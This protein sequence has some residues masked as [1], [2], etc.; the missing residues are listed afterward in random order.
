MKTRLKSQIIEAAHRL[1]FPLAGVTTPD[2]PAGMQRYESWLA[3]GYHGD[4]DYL[5]SERARNRRADPGLILPDCRSILMLATPYYPASLLAQEELQIAA[6]ALGR[7]YH[8]TLVERMNLLADTIAALTG[9]PFAGKVYTDTGPLLEREL[10]HRAGLGWIGRNSCLIHPQYGSHLL[11]SE[12]LLDLDLEPD[13]PFEKDLCGTCQR[14]LQACPT[15]CILDN[16]TLDATRCISYLTIESRGPIPE[17][18]R[19]A[20]GERFFGC[21]TCQD[22]CPWNQHS[23]ASSDDPAFQ[24]SARLLSSSLVDFITLDPQRWRAPYK[25]SPLLRAKR[26]GLARNA[27]VVAGNRRDAGLLPAL[28][29]ALRSDPDPLVRQHAAWAMG[30]IGGKAARCA[31]KKAAGCENNAD[32]Q[33]A[34]QHASRMN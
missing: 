21:D 29:T 11:L 25:E 16:R 12:I 8:Y 27:C 20:I 30:R 13:A 5:A 18:L 4:M 26:R 31:L 6:Y 15:A 22:V 1:G 7:D 2:P 10:A 28:E 34:I 32:V 3:A 33:A 24:P 17:E 9:K 23:N 14:C 19:E